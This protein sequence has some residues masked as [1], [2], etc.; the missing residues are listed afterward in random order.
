MQVSFEGGKPEFTQ[1]LDSFPF[2]YY[3]VLQDVAALPRTLADLMRQW[4][5]LTRN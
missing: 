5:Q 1:Y 3:I 4:F 2:P